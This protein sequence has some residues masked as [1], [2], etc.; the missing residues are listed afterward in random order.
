MFCGKDGKVA[1]AV[2]QCQVGGKG[3]GSG[4]W[5]DLWEDDAWSAECMPR[6]CNGYSEPPVGLEKYIVPEPD[7][8]NVC[9]KWKCGGGFKF[10]TQTNKCIPKF[11]DGS[12]PDEQE[13]NLPVYKIQYIES[14]DCFEWDCIDGYEVQDR[15]C[16]KLNSSGTAE[17]SDPLPSPVAGYDPYN[18][19][20]AK[21]QALI[22][23]MEE[24]CGPAA[25]AADNQTLQSAKS[26]TK[27]QN[28]KQAT[29]K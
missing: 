29:K 7:I 6:W 2:R 3:K 14:K 21:I 12:G 8:E 18:D 19:L 22:Q 10:N 15:H 13:Y 16:V 5:S 27:Q 24:E 9:W 17:S 28:K 23:E 25:I 26:S 11:C 20:I 1:A 4:W